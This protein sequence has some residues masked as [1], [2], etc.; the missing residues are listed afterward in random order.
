MLPKK[1]R[2]TKAKD[3]QQVLRSRLGAGDKVLQI[4]AS[5][6][7]LEISRF[8]VVASLKVD[9]WATKR[10]HLKR[11]LRE[12]VRLNLDKIKVGYDFVIIA[13]RPALKLE[14]QQLEESLLALLQSLKL[15]K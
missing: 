11:Q 2:L 6:K 14:Y 3:I 10:N 7:S 15:L 5:K 12:V 13:L 4:R 1:H 9:K 8:T